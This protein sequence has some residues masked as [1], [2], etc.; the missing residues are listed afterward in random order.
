MLNR[1]LRESNREREG[2]GAGVN[3]PDGRAVS[4]G[5]VAGEEQLKKLE[6]WVEL[7]LVTVG[8]SYTNI[9]TMWISSRRSE[10]LTGEADEVTRLLKPEQVGV[11]M[12]FKYLSL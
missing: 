5:V 1:L 9:S 10:L 3:K 7:A 11:F 4:L 6:S 8:E 12:R 2:V